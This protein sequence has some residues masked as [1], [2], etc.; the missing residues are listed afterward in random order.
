VGGGRAAGVMGTGGEAG[1]LG[2]G[3][4]SGSGAAAGGGSGGGT[5]GA[6][7]GDEH[8]GDGVAPSTDPKT[9][10]EKLRLARNDN[11]DLTSQLHEARK[12]MAHDAATKRGL[13]TSLSEAEGALA[14]TKEQ[15]RKS[16]LT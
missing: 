14:E 10:R 2:S 5:G 11:N 12:V 15:L 9:L 4:G 13:A 3:S 6:T 16:T 8:E 1:K 7:A